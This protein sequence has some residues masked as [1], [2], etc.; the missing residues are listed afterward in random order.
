MYCVLV[1]ANL[2]SF[3]FWSSSFFF[4]RLFQ[5][6]SRPKSSLSIRRP[7]TVSLTRADEQS[8][9]AGNIMVGDES[10]VTGE[11]ER[12]GKSDMRSKTL[13]TIE[14]REID[15]Q[16]QPQDEEEEG[17]GKAIDVEAEAEKVSEGEPE[18]TKMETKKVTDEEDKSQIQHQGRDNACLSASTPPAPRPV[19]ASVASSQTEISGGSRTLLTDPL[20]SKMTDSEVASD[21]SSDKSMQSNEPTGNTIAGSGDIKSIHDT[22]GTEYYTAAASVDNFSPASGE[23]KDDAPN[24]AGDHQPPHKRMDE[25]QAAGPGVAEDSADILASSASDGQE[26]VQDL[27]EESREVRDNNVGDNVKENESMEDSCNDTPIKA[28]VQTEAGGGPGDHHQGDKDKPQSNL[29]LP[30]RPSIQALH[31]SPTAMPTVPRRDYSNI[32]MPTRRKSLP[33]I[34]SKRPALLLGPHKRVLSAKP[35]LADGRITTTSQ[36]Y[37]QGETAVQAKQ[38]LLSLTG[39]RASGRHRKSSLTSSGSRTSV[40]TADDVSLAEKTGSNDGERLTDTT[41]SPPQFPDNEHMLEDT[42]ASKQVSLAQADGNV[43]GDAE[44]ANLDSITIPPLAAA[45]VCDQDSVLASSLPLPESDI[46]TSSLLNFPTDTANKEVVTENPAEAERCDSEQ[47]AG[48]GQSQMDGAGSKEEHHLDEENNLDCTGTQ[49]EEQN[50]EKSRTEEEDTGEAALSAS[51]DSPSPSRDSPSP[52]RDSPSPSRD[53]PSPSRDSP[54]P[55]RDS[56]VPSQASPSPSQVPEL[57]EP[58]SAD[59]PEGGSTSLGTEGGDDVRSEVSATTLGSKNISL[60]ERSCCSSQGEGSDQGSL[61]GSAG[62]NPENNVGAGYSDD[63]FEAKSN[64]S[65]SNSDRDE[66]KLDETG[67]LNKENTSVDGTRSHD[68]QDL[69]NGEN[70]GSGDD[71]SDGHSIGAAQQDLGAGP[72]LTSV[73]SGT[74]IQDHLSEDE[75]ARISN[76]QSA[77]VESASLANDNADEVNKAAQ[78]EMTQ[79]PE[80]P[81]IPTHSSSD[82]NINPQQAEGSSSNTLGCSCNQDGEKDEAEVM[83]SSPYEPTTEAERNQ[84]KSDEVTPAEEPT[85]AEQ[86]DDGTKTHDGVEMDTLSPDVGRSTAASELLL[87]PGQP[88]GDMTS[89][90]TTVGGEDTVQEEADHTLLVDSVAELADQA[91]IQP[92]DPEEEVPTE[93]SPEGDAATATISTALDNAQLAQGV[94]E[95]QQY[96][97]IEPVAPLEAAVVTSSG[98]DGTA[99]ATKADLSKTKEAQELDETQQDDNACMV[100]Q[101]LN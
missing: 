7:G 89:P 85:I 67:S 16:G 47:E 58:M 51:R 25:D 94:K 95:M 5:I 22:D 52:S 41:V 55:S 77:N 24:G 100:R 56:P 54:S 2:I 64:P 65:L 36:P 28:S 72:S 43:S 30:T 74:D 26:A 62:E 40:A 49:E 73:A 31:R 66:E 35:A 90:D 15:E 21:A 6:L 11:K 14:D 20:V 76:E 29:E 81:A 83:A 12:P 87:M 86:L 101:S 75:T 79:Q 69:D 19:A 84:S 8:G 82:S 10:T 59:S 97:E 57:A 96:P 50:E 68:A 99:A 91:E 44:G 78:A 23:I 39:R 70:H 4:C 71:G 61:T 98:A 37:A 18:D 3:L 34:T 46:E 33:A 92:P 80:E 9:Q 17:E 38:P 42:A 63:D 48:D 13:A 88:V 60:D 45:S 27:E 1:F 32:A 53:S 93:S